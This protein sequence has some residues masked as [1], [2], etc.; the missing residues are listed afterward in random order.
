MIL[1]KEFYF[2]RHGQTDHNIQGFHADHIDIPLNPAGRR[3]AREIEPLITSLPIKTICFSPLI[4]AKETKEIVTAKLLATQYEIVDLKECTGSVWEKMT[5]LGPHAPFKAQG[6]VQTF[7]E[8]ARNGINQA[9]S[10]PGPVL[11]VAHGGIYWA[12]CSFMLVDHE[13]RI[14]NCV[15]VHF[16]IGTDGKWRAEKLI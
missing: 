10:Q 14:D 15:P 11:I 13:W 2:I 9:L 4:R 12:M 8:Q 1:Q 5:S 3:Q 7:M 6:E 16:F